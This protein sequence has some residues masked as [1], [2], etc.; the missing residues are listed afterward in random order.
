MPGVETMLP[1]FL[2][3]A[4]KEVIPFSK[5]ISLLCEKPAELLN[6]PKGYIQIGKDADLIVVDIK[7]ETKIKSENLHSKCKWSAFEDW[8]AIFPTHVFIRGEKVI[9]DNEIQVS[10]GFGRFV[11][12]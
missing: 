7:K 5:V 11:G 10:Q 9:E 2:F 1:L 3:F 8:E 4:K 6:A 12:E